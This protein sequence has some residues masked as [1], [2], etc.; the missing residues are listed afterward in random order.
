ME[1]SQPSHVTNPQLQV[2]T[3]TARPRS[4][5][6]IWR[7]TIYLRR[8][9]YF[10]FLI[11]L[12][13][14]LTLPAYVL[15]LF[16]R[17]VYRRYLEGLIDF[18]NAA[19]SGYSQALRDVRDHL[20]TLEYFWQTNDGD[21]LE[22]YGAALE[23]ADW[24]QGATILDVGTGA[25]RKAYELAKRGAQRVIGVDTSH[26]NIAVAKTMSGQVSNL[27]FRDVDAKD[28]MPEFPAAF[29]YIVSFTVFEHVDHPA[30]LLR[31]LYHLQKPG[32]KQVIVFNHFDDKNGS[33]LKE[34]VWLPWPQLVF[35]ESILYDYWNR[36]MAAAQ[37]RG[38]MGYFP[39]GYRHG[40]GK[41]NEDCYMNLNRVSIEE[42]RRQVAR[43]PYTIEREYYYSPSPLLT[44][45]PWLRRTFLSR[46][47]VGSVAYVLKK[48]L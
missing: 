17:T 1:H 44:I 9:I 22:L 2:T 31:D 36:H 16:S 24:F 20:K 27:E 13:K 35:P 10:W 37:A 26:R 14:V 11:V 30:Q 45:W 41:H 4:L 40:F 12:L 47:L 33:H 29:D 38:E 15:W 6:N 43:T 39:P 5:A 23:D 28:L 3:G 7:S 48:P 32:G 19:V 21:G 34:F 18:S 8:E 42:F 25:G 46:W